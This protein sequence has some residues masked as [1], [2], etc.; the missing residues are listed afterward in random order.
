MT[1]ETDF[2]YKLYDNKLRGDTTY[3]YQKIGVPIGNAR[4]NQKVRFRIE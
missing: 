4:M 1:S 2:Y 3:Y